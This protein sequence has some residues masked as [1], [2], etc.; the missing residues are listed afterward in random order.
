[1]RLEESH[2]LL[3]PRRD[4]EGVEAH[5][6]G[7]LGFSKLHYPT[8]ALS[9]K[10]QAFTSD[11][12]VE[13]IAPG[14][15]IDAASVSLPLPAQLTLPDNRPVLTILTGKNPYLKNECIAGNELRAA[16]YVIER[17]Q[18]RR[19]LEWPVSTCSLGRAMRFELTPEGS[20]IIGYTNGSTVNFTFSTDHFERTE[21]GAR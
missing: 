19:A 5:E 4:V 8:W 16:L 6:T 17:N 12:L 21:M 20:L 11:T 2:L 13:L 9:L 18:A 1:M 10:D 7:W 15:A 14:L 3:P